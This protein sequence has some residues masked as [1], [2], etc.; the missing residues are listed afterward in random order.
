M[1]SRFVL[2]FQCY[3]KKRSHYCFTE[4]VNVFT[5]GSLL[6]QCYSKKRSHYCFTEAVKV[7]HVWFSLVSVLQ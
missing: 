1:F 3:S 6:F 4:A 2:L 5:F 7:F